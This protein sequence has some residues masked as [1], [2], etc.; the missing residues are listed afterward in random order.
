MDNN[1][2]RSIAL[3]FFFALQDDRKAADLATDAVG[4]ARDRRKRR[5][6]ETSAQT[7]IAATFEIWEE[8]RRQLRKQKGAVVQSINAGWFRPSVDAAPWSEFRKTSA[9]E[10]LA[11]AIWSGI[12]GYSPAHIAAALALPEGTVRYRLSS[13][14]QKLGMAVTGSR[15]A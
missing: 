11:T 3:F 13:A 4:R 14:L 10:E 6:N 5:P 7:V 15:K 8:E 1:D 9:P 12:L 2:I